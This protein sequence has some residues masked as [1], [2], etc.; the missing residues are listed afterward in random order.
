MDVGNGLVDTLQEWALPMSGGVVRAESNSEIVPRVWHSIVPFC[1]LPST[2][3]DL[4]TSCLT[5]PSLT[6]SPHWSSSAHPRACSRSSHLAPALFLAVT[7]KDGTYTVLP[8]T[9][10]PERDVMLRLYN[11]MGMYGAKEIP[12]EN[13]LRLGVRL[14][15]VDDFVR[16]RLAP[17]L[18]IP[19]AG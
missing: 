16:S 2:I 1:L 3:G 11:E 19:S 7:G 8:T 6:P 9:H 13:V 14:H 5:R 12:D 15:D 17:H 18:G 4:Q 10:V